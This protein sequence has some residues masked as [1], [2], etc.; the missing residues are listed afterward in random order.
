MGTYVCRHEALSKL[1]MFLD[2]VEW[3]RIKE[4]KDLILVPLKQS[5][6]IKLR[7]FT[8]VQPCS[9]TLTSLLPL[10]PGNKGPLMKTGDGSETS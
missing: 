8:S 2:L 5:K 10:L 7:L 6:V 9:F 4:I 3:E 1:T